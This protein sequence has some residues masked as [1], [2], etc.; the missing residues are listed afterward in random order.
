MITVII[1][2]GSGTRLWPISLPEYPK[3]LLKIDGHK[4]TLLQQTYQRAKRLG[5]QIYVVSE[6][7]HIKY[8]KEQLPELSGNNFISEPARRGTANCII[9][10]LVK[11]KDE[12]NKDEPIAILSAD[13]Y[14][15][16]TDGFEQTF[17]IASK[18]SNQYKQIA[19]IGI[20]PLYPAT[21]FGYIKKDKLLTHDNSAYSVHSFKEKPDFKTAK[22]YLETGKYLWNCGYFVASFNTFI[23]QL[24]V[25]AK[26]LYKNY[27]TL[28]SSEEKFNQNYLNLENQTID[29][30]LIEKVKN[31]IVVPASFD[32]LD[33][34][35]YSDL[36]KAVDSD[37]KGNH[38]KGKNIE[39]FEIENCFI[40]NYEDK[41]LITIGLNNIVIVN[42][43]KGILITRKDLSQKVG[44]LSKKFYKK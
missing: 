11:I 4:L 30:G 26:S 44:E 34:G 25:Y 28:E 6:V 14:I 43:P 13:H 40:Q 9:A 23:K 35:S 8:V 27:K 12:I 22:K 32:W 16:D 10:T 42:T 5:S 1:A 3:H 37:Q 20:E 2:G 7:G 18:M 24:E 17:K 19:L 29:Y 38:F 41:P 33:L 21:G 36:H 15:R 31:L 39:S